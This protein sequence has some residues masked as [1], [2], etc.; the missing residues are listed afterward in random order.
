MKEL[1]LLPVQF[2]TMPCALRPA[3]ALPAAVAAL[4]AVAALIFSPMGLG[5]PTPRADSGAAVL[6]VEQLRDV[7]PPLIF[8]VIFEVK[9]I[10]A[11]DEEAYN[12]KCQSV[13]C[14]IE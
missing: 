13:H 8:I 7:E 11:H 5:E 12:N 2:W 6:V 9:G 1:R 10:E 4:L 14:K 3:Y